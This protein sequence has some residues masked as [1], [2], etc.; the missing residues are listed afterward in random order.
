MDDVEGVVR[1]A[2]KEAAK[3]RAERQRAKE[4]AAPLYM[5]DR[6]A[7]DKPLPSVE[8]VSLLSKAA[9]EGKGGGPSVPQVVRLLTRRMVGAGDEE[10]ERRAVAEHVVRLMKEDLFVE[11]MLGLRFRYGL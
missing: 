10:E 4:R 3:T 2:G 11:L 9:A 7:R 5:T 1:A 6:V 8:V